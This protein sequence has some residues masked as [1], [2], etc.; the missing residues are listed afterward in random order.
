[1]ITILTSAFKIPPD[2]YMLL[3]LL[4]LREKRI[5]LMPKM[6]ARLRQ[7]FCVF[8]FQPLAA[9]LQRVRCW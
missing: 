5:F 9:I 8:V 1:M 2:Q 4:I 3:I 6:H 7:H